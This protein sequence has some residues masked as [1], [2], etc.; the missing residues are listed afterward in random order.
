MEANTFIVIPERVIKEANQAIDEANNSFERVLLVGEEYKQ[1]G[2]TP[3]YLLDP[4]YMDVYVYCQETL[5]KK[6][7]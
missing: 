5:R 3:I 2:L 7:H 6:L 4:E 1:A